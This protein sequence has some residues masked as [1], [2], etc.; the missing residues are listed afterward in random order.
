MKHLSTKIIFLV[1]ALTALCRLDAR[2]ENEQLTLMA[3]DVFAVKGQNAHLVIYVEGGTRPYNVVWYDDNKVEIDSDSFSQSSASIQFKAY[4]SEDITVMVT[5]ADGEVATAVQRI[6]V[7]TDDVTSA[8][9]DDIYFGMSRHLNGRYKRTDDAPEKGWYNSFINGSFVFHSLSST[10]GVSRPTTGCTV[11]NLKASE[12]KP[13]DNDFVYAAVTEGGY[14]QSPAYVTVCD[15]AYITFADEGS[16]VYPL[17][18]FYINSSAAMYNSVINGSAFSPMFVKGDYAYVTISNEAEGKSIDYYIADYRSDNEYDHYCL[19]TWQWVDLRPLGKITGTLKLRFRSNHLVEGDMTGFVMPAIFCIDNFNGTCEIIKA[20][21]QNVTLGS[22]IH[23][24]NIMPLPDIP[25]TVTYEITDIE[26]GYSDD[27]HFDIKDYDLIVNA[28][29]CNVRITVKQKYAGLTYYASIPVVVNGTQAKADFENLNIES[30]SYVS[31]ENKT[32]TSGSYRFT[33]DVNA[34]NGFTYSSISTIGVDRQLQFH[35]SEAGGGYSLSNNYAVLT[36][37]GSVSTISPEHQIS[38]FYVTSS[39]ATYSDVTNG[40]SDLTRP[41]AQGDSLVLTIVNTDNGRKICYPIA[42]YRS[43]NAADHYCLDTW[44]WVDLRSLGTANTL[45]LYLSSSQMLPDGNTGFQLNPF[46]CID[47]FGGSRVVTQHPAVAFQFSGPCLAE[48]PLADYFTFENQGASTITYTIDEI[49]G[50]DER[51]SA[52]IEDGILEFG[53][54]NE[55]TF[56]V[57]VR[58]FCRGIVQ[59]ASIP[60]TFTADINNASSDAGIAARYTLGGTRVS[61]N[62]DGGVN[63]IRCIDGTVKK[64]VV[65]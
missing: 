62:T 12:Y 30:E 5:D 52:A 26:G 64:V 36:D 19:N 14:K 44:Q 65:R 51:S 9:F 49:T 25:A 46:C 15:S 24:A 31:P 10:I 4:C 18:G 21:V 8:T 27:A 61:G 41:F 1:F 23:L 38:G 20:P 11:T 57:V 37:S 50:L 6:I 54:N 43:D 48:L 17:S 22:A 58:A 42:D 63:I 35:A 60:V 56:T 45:S 29:Q 32:F 28:S 16:S 40:Y 33:S 39:A 2:A 7:R 59:Y 53:I 3:P 13:S 55:T 47:D 34:D